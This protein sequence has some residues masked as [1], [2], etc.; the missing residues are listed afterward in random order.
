[1]EKFLCKK[2]EKVFEKITRLNDA[3]NQEVLGYLGVNIQQ[4]RLPMQTSPA[5]SRLNA[6][7][8]KRYGTLWRETET[9]SMVQ[10]GQI[11]HVNSLGVLYATP[12]RGEW[13]RSV[14]R[15]GR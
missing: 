15:S 9:Q 2:R 14:E 3:M 13:V 1:M 10:R 7:G 11:Q 12:A 5:R 6:F 4:K 8:G